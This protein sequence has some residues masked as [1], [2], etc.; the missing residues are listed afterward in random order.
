MSGPGPDDTTRAAPAVRV[1]RPVGE[2][3][4]ATAD[5]LDRRLHDVPVDA[6]LVVDLTEVT[7]VDSVTLS[8]FV[9]AAR[10]HDAAGTS[11][12]LAGATGIVERVLTI[13]KL[14]AVLS[15]VPSVDEA[16]DLL[17]AR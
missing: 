15:C 1:V 14:D 16:Q 6:H 17:D 3:D 4:I 12:V 10:R 2:L 11:V 13:T 9:R 7:F 5:E 8:R